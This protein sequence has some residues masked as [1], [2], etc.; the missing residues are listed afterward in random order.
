MAS[1]R[2]SQFGKQHTSMSLVCALLA[3]STSW[4]VLAGAAHGQ[5]T[6]TTL[7]DSLGDAL[8]RPMD[9]GAAL[10]FDAASHRLIDLRSIT[11][12]T[13]AP[14]APTADLFAGEYGADGE[15]LRL[16]LA[17]DGLVNPPG[18]ADPFSFDP[19]RYGDHP[20]YG[21]VEID[22]D[23][24]VNTGGELFAPQYRYLGNAV[25]FGGNVLR[26]EFADRVALDGSDFDDNF[27]TPPFVE[28]HGEEF[29]LALIGG[30]FGPGDIE[31]VE[32]NGNV[33][34]EAGE[35]WNIRGPFFHRAHAYE[36]F[37]FVEGGQYPGEYAPVC[38]LQFRH[39]P[40]E[41]ITYL[42]LIFPLT[43][44]GAGL[45]RGE[46]P[47]PVN[48]D[49]TDQASV[50]EA[51]WDLQLSAFLLDILPTGL[52]EEDIIVNWADRNPPDHLDPAT[53]SVTALLGSSYTA[54]HPTD[55]YFLWSDIYPNVVGGD[56][57][58]SG[59][60]DAQDTQLIARHIAN[61][62]SLDGFVDGIVTIVAFASDF[63]VFDVNHDGV[64]SAM[65]LTWNVRDGDS[66]QDGDVDLA[67]FA[68]L[69]RCF[70]AAGAPSATCRL[71]DVVNDL[72][73]DLAD[74][75]E[76]GNRLTGPR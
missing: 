12:G 6:S 23:N 8:A 46:P 26:P 72:T 39:Q 4:L 75:A 31:E 42:T 20:V 25:R 63:S 64:V 35:T 40:A 62:D 59:V 32:G 27:L 41:D 19:F 70:G 17:L 50:L 52:P 56:V 51:L 22:V 76:F 58:G 14:D 34:F 13:W 71:L 29:H 15:F 45:M 47:E 21:F 61:W 53:W 66:D 43:N 7:N 54:P 33:L 37:S 30:Q 16:E 55:I 1:K 2:K 18:S 48:Q 3:V 68:S 65:D 28:R 69:Q 57:D 73:I 60:T 36:L 10:P 5:T 49:P 11:I 74:V 44:V 24:D 9:P 67:D 38:D